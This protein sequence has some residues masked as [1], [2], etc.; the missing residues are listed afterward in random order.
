MFQKRVY[1]VIIFVFCSEILFSQQQILAKQISTST[2]ETDE[3][4]GFDNQQ[5]YYS[6]KNNVCNSFTQLI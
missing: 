2:L 4:L 6:I 5:K 1:L 3:F